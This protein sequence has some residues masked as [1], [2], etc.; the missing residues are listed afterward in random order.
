MHLKVF[1]NLSLLLPLYLFSYSEERALNNLTS[2]YT[3]CTA[4]YKIVEG[5]AKN[6]NDS[7]LEKKANEMAEVMFNLAV[8]SS[9]RTTSEASSYQLNHKK[10]TWI[11]III[12]SRDY[13]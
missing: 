3:D 9:N 13:F 1:A 5:G 12:T 10:K 8:I 6:S 4:Y 11:T 7:K 2:D